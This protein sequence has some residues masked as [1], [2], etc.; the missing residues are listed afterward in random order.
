MTT[1]QPN[2]A[3]RRTTITTIEQGGTQAE[4]E[5]R[6]SARARACNRTCSHMKSC[7]AYMLLAIAASSGGD[8]VMMHAAYLGSRGS[9]GSEGVRV[10]D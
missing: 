5:R 9:D 4:G 7:G 10:C 6:Q 2:D 8:S 1:A 3:Q